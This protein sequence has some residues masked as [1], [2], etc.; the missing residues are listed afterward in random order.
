[1]QQ[2]RVSAV[3]QLQA[4]LQPALQEEGFQA[5]QT[6]HLFT[7]VT[8]CAQLVI[9]LLRMMHM[10]DHRSLKWWKPV[11]SGGW[12]CRVMALPWLEVKWPQVPWVLG[13]RYL[14]QTFLQLNHGLLEFDKN[15]WIC[16][17]L[18]QA[19]SFH[20]AIG[21]NFCI[22]PDF[23]MLIIHQYD[24]CIEH[25]YVSIL[26]DITKSSYDELKANA[27]CLQNV[28]TKK[29]WEMNG[30]SHS[31]KKLLLWAWNVFCP[32][33]SNRLSGKAK[34]CTR[35]W[36][37]KLSSLILRCHVNQMFVIIAQ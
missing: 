16:W 17:R 20:Q 15:V 37:P 8:S 5:E 32:Q 19:E 27:W 12:A 6:P 35:I 18:L 13:H 24:W 34:Q 25:I 4:G 29:H 28:E 21:A 22:I 9:I 10:S 7:Q 26:T 11:L 3:P 31:P 1:M 2:R 23:D 33:S 14:L 36:S 30:L